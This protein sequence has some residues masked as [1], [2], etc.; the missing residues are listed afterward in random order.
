MLALK[1]VLRDITAALRHIIMLIKSLILMFRN[2]VDML[3]SCTRS[4]IR[5]RSDIM[6]QY[7]DGAIA[8]E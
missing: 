8:N 7:I 1:P 2:D 5:P 6:E 3:G 4:S